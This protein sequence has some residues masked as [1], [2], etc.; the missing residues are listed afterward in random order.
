MIETGAPVKRNQRGFLSQFVTC[1][2]ELC[3][4][5]IEEQP[6]PVDTRI[7]RILPV[8]WG[9]EHRLR[10]S[11]FRQDVIPRDDTSVGFEATSRI[12]PGVDKPAI[13]TPSTRRSRWACCWNGFTSFN[14]SR[15]SPGLGARPY[16]I[17]LRK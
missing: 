13:V 16:V 1:N 15:A 7:N 12:A 4:Y 8:P 14:Q 10:P 17:R 6:C 9:S 3:S 2:G 5:D 11:L